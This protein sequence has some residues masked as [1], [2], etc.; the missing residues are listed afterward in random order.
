M[1]SSFRV[2]TIASALLVSILGVGVGTAS[3]G[4][5]KCTPLTNGKLCSRA[6]T[7]YNMVTMSYV[8]TGGSTIRVRFGY[9]VNGV[10]R[11]VG[12]WQTFTVPS[13]GGD[14][15]TGNYGNPCVNS[16]M[17]VEGQGKFWVYNVCP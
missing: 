9:T 2:L 3:A 6:K 14:G 12:G 11:E 13:G 7:E 15:F 16:F 5:E 10:T 4:P 17:E 8:K 1:Q